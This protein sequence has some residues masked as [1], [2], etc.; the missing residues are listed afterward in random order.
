MNPN[1]LV[2]S[3]KKYLTNIVL[4]LDLIFSSIGIYLITQGLISGLIIQA[5]H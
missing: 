4:D 1:N 2:R 5:I 3:I